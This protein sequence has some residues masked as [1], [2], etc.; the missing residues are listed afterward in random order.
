MVVVSGKTWVSGK[1][2]F[3]LMQGEMEIFDTSN[4]A[5]GN[6]LFIKSNFGFRLSTE[7]ILTTRN[8]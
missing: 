4:K 7:F 5:F 1:N 6:P 2:F 3:G 8:E